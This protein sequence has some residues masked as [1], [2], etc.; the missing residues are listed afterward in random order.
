MRSVRKREYE[1]WFADFVLNP[2]LLAAL[3]DAVL[4]VSL[5]ICARQLDEVR[6]GR[7]RDPDRRRP[8]RAAEPDDVPRYVLRPDQAT[9]G[10]PL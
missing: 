8:G 9:P 7:G 2:D 3:F 10:P 5:A 1:D 6:R 4:E